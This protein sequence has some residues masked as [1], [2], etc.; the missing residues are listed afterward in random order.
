MILRFFEIQIL[1]E[2][3]FLTFLACGSRLYV[4]FICLLKLRETWFL[5]HHSLAIVKSFF[6]D[7]M[8]EYENNFQI[9]LKFNVVILLILES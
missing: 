9:F 3:L 8:S 2:I 1:F 4:C 6:F 5:S 7:Q